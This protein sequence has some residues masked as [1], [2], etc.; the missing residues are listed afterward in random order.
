MTLDTFLDKWKREV[1]CNNVCISTSRYYAGDSIT[2][3]YER[4]DR[5]TEYFIVQDIYKMGYFKVR[6]Y[7]Y[8]QRTKLYYN[9]E[10]YQK[11]R[12]NF[13]NLSIL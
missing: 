5:M 12:E 2:I 6:R 11:Y 10:Q 8:L 1:D 3:N 9:E 7:Q 4:L 13:Y